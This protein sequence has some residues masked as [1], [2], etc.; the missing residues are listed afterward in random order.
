MPNNNPE[1]PPLNDINQWPIFLFHSSP[2]ISPM[3][4]LNGTAKLC[5]CFPSQ[6]SSKAS[7]TA[8]AILLQKMARLLPLVLSFLVLAVTCYAQ[9]TNSTTLVPAIM[10]F[11]DSSVDV[12]NNNYLPTIFKANFPPYGRDFVNH[13]PTGRFCNGK[14]VTDF[15]GK[16]TRAPLL[17]PR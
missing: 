4:S 13:E 3:P 8:P 17:T 1:S 6:L 10:T 16:S 5:H 7:L 2:A 15:T 12:G 14:L 11:G 9:D